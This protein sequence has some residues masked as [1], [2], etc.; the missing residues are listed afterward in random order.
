MNLFKLYIR[1]AHEYN[2]SAWMLYQADD[3]K[4]IESVQATFTRLVCRKLNIRYDS[5]K[6]H[7]NFLNFDTLEIRQT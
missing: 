6:H 2:I 7:F 1:P 3:I 5:Y 4:K